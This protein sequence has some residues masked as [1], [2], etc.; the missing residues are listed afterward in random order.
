MKQFVTI[1]R[2]LFVTF[3]L[4]CFARN[5]PAVTY[6]VDVNSTNPT[7][8]YTNWYTAATN[9]QNAVDLANPGDLVLVTNGIYIGGER[10]VS[11]LTTN[12]VVV[13]NAITVQSIGGPSVTVI[14]AY[15]VA[16]NTNGTLRCVYLGSGSTLSGFTLENGATKSDSGAGIYCDSSNA[17]IFD[18][19]ITGN[20]AR[21]DGGGI[22]F[23]ST[24]ELVTNCII[25]DNS[26]GSS[27]GGVYSGYGS[28]G[29]YS[30]C[31]ISSNTASGGGG[32]VFLGPNSIMD[33]CVINGN[34]S[35][36][37][38]GGIYCEYVP[39]ALINCTIVGNHSSSSGGGG[40]VYGIPNAISLTNCII[41]YNTE[42]AFS[43]AGTNIAIITN[44]YNCC[45][46]PTNGLGA[47]NIAGAPGFVNIDAGNF[48]LA[49]WSPCIDAG[50]DAA[51]TNATDLDGNPR[52]VNG[53]VDIGAYEYQY[54]FTQTVHYVVLANANAVSPFTNW[55]TAATSIQA[56]INAAAPGDFIVVSNGIYNTGGSAV[57]GVQTNRMVVDVPVTVQGLSGAGF[58]LIE[59]YPYYPGIRC[60]YLT[61]GATLIGLTLTNGAAY[62]DDY[63]STDDGGGVCCADTSATLLNC[64]ITGNWAANSGGGSFSGTLINCILTN[65]LTLV[66][67]GGACFGVISN[68][69]LVD[70]YSIENVREN[71]GGG[72]CSNTL[73]NCVLA[74]NWSTYAGGGAYSC[75]LSNCTL[76]GNWATNS[77]GGTYACTL[78]NCV[79]FGNHATNGGGAADSLLVNCTLTNNSAWNGGASASNTLDNCLLAHNVATNEGGGVFAGTLN[80]CIILSNSASQY[81]GGAIFG[82]LSN[83]TLTGNSAYYGGGAC[84][85]ALNN[86]T[87]AYNTANYGGGVD[88][89]ILNNCTI[90]NNSATFGGG[91]GAFG[92]VLNFCNLFNNH[93]VGEPGAV[94]AGG[95]YKGTLTGCVLSNNIC[96]AF[97]AGGAA[98]ATLTDCLII[99]NQISGGAYECSLNNCTV[100]F[101]SAETIAGISPGV[102]ECEATNSIIYY[103]VNGEDTNY[104]EGFF[105]NCCTYPMPSAF[106]NLGGNITNAP[107][108]V[109]TNGDFHLQSNSPCINSGNNAYVMSATDLDGN[110][111]IVGGTVDIGAYEYQTPASIISYAWLQQ[112]GLPTDGSADSED[113]DG[114]AF[115]V[116]QDWIAGLNPTNSASI[117][118]M[119][120]PVVTNNASGATISWQS[121]SG[122]DYYLQSST[123]LFAQPAFFIIQSNIVG[124]AGT[125]SYTDTTATNSGPYFYRVGVLQQ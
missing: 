122:I 27:G 10:V 49:A 74:Q 56:A 94:A 77:G 84:S 78:T 101:N 24:N 76:S 71:F 66:Q 70:N 79:F 91:G 81:G 28:T 18:C 53:I 37:A 72:A 36:G 67:G 75:V 11:G 57:Y 25:T 99:S 34:S 90:N 3:F 68:S 83:C 33:N 105:E 62:Y 103:N 38:G 55:M 115:N 30:D 9:I 86:C 64:I 100:A 35:Q 20:S 88:G 19:V 22:Y 26:A 119:L 73:Y 21:F 97:G 51:V 48:R 104:A 112:Y 13:T 12:C 16:G 111:R 69:L 41:Y 52:I 39:S 65:N 85:N 2:L 1:R 95:A 42:G 80:N 32:G 92:A 23:Q 46:T 118:V 29:T 63:P 60:A 98:L 109:N 59:G 58:T 114:T 87:V 6:Y 44:V 45:T 4:G 117:L 96:S 82:T 5:A 93:I 120:P 17:V 31:V 43:S 47:N 61:S 8:P 121:I 124:Q 50:D 15:P 7:P 108:F 107:L 40:G 89:G 116:Y 54:Q 113:L 125:T 110:P 123:N 106:G 14:Q 102:Y